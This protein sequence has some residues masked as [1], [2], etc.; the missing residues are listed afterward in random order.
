M[1]EK[2]K[3]KASKLGLIITCILA[4]VVVY[5]FGICLPKLPYSQMSMDTFWANKISNS[6]KYDIVFIGD[7]RIYRGINPTIISQ[8]TNS[9]TVNYGF[10]AAGLDSNLIFSGIRQLKKDGKNIVVFG[11][12]PSSFT[13]EASKNE[14]LKSLEKISTK[15]LW[16]RKNIYPYLS[17]FDSYNLSEI[18]KAIKN[19][20]YSQVCQ[21]DGFIYS[22]KFPVDSLAALQDYSDYFKRTSI[23][24]SQQIKFLNLLKELNVR[25]IKCFAFRVPVSSPMS[26]LESQYFDFEAFKIKLESIGTHWISVPQN[27]FISYD[28]SHLDGPSA[29]KLSS[30]LG[31]SILNYH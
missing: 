23:S 1:S 2:N 6:K 12:T 8:I 30:I 13:N 20:S 9:K 27:G 15:D 31:D 3:I 26:K 22:N 18:K 24:E 21:A 28:G 25:G 10:S 19:E 4:P 16:I 29:N 5:L 7:S 14:H 11:I 17:F